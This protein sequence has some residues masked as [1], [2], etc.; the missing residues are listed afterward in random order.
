MFKPGFLLD[1]PEKLRAAMFNGSN[2][3]IWENGKIADYGGPIEAIKDE[4]VRIG[5][6]Y[7]NSQQ[8]EFRIR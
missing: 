3:T 1:T 5:G 2:V 6:I 8:H 4:F 7:Y